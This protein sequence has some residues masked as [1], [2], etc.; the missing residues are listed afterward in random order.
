MR[1][2]SI[3]VYLVEL[4]LRRALFGPASGLPTLQTV[5]VRLGS[6]SDAGWGEAAP[7]SA[8]LAY[9][10]WS[11][12]TYA[13]LKDWLGPAVVGRDVD[14]A[15]SLE[16][17][18]ERFRGHRFAKA[19]IDL[20]WWDLRA[21]REGRPLHRLLGGTRDDF[22]VGATLDRMDSPEQFLGEVG[23]VFEQGYARLKLKFRPGW[24]VRMLEAVRRDYPAPAIQ[25]DVE[26][27]LHMGHFE[28]LCRLDDFM[29]TMIEQPL[30]REDLVAHAM[31]Q[32]AVRTPI[33]LDESI[34]TPAQADM[35]MDLKSCRYVNLKADRVGGLAAARKIHD[36]C[37]NA[38][39][40]CFAGATPQ[41]SFG[42]R[43]AAALATL[44]NCAESPADFFPAAE[45]LAEDLVE[46]LVPRRG[47]DG[48]LRVALDAS[49]APE[50]DPAVLQRRAIAQ[51]TLR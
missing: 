34:E 25:I 35:A 26:G 7:G 39:V 29:L 10:D 27:G 28:M 44:P 9:A 22:A 15:E 36:I 17:L 5:L 13:A 38:C 11:A 47:D 2:D 41:S 23:R 6:G 24:D 43:A 31:L 45:L 20:A 16:S 32:D 14:S 12:G 50:P 51:A 4:P 42:A 33:C 19:A 8:P 18:L 48:M 46:P 30:A 40:P 3:D 37:H 21:R 1:I 49:V